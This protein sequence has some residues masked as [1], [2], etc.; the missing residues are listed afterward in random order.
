MEGIIHIF[1]PI[2]T[3]KVWF[4]P[5]FTKFSVG[6]AQIEVPTFLHNFRLKMHWTMKEPGLVLTSLLSILKLSFLQSIHDP[7]LIFIPSLQPDLFWSRKRTREHSSMTWTQGFLSPVTSSCI[8]TR[9][10]VTKPTFCLSFIACSVWWVER[11]FY[12]ASAP[13]DAIW[14][15][16]KVAGISRL[17]IG[18]LSEEVNKRNTTWRLSSAWSN[19]AQELWRI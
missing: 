16:L 17:L 9:V 12:K 7:L 10:S 5:F 19:T 18:S 6:K 11:N 14:K 3:K 4:Q 15:T 8:Q 13:T 2:F 1:R